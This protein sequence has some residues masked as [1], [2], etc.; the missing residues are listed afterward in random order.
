VLNA[1][2]SGVP[3]CYRQR[4]LVSENTLEAPP[5]PT[6][7]TSGE[8]RTDGGGSAL[9]LLRRYR[10]WV[11]A[12][13]LLLFSFGLLEWAKTRPGYDPFGWLVW[14]YQSIHFSLNLGGAPSWKPLPLLLT[15]PFAIFGVH[16]ELWLW[17]VS[18]V[19]ISL[20]GTIFAGRIA[21]RLI[22]VGEDGDRRPALIGAVFAGASVLG[23]SDY[24]HI[25]LSVQSDPMIV[26]LFVAA[27]DAYLSGK[28]RLAFALGILAGI[29]RPEVWSTTI[30]FTIWLWYKRPEFRKLLIAGWIFTLFMWFGIPTLTNGRPFIA[31]QLALRSPRAPKGNLVIASFHRFTG[32][33]Y[34]PVQLGALVAIVMAWRRKNWLVLLVAASAVIWVLTETALDLKGLPGQPR[35]IFEP[36]ALEGSL[37]GIA[38]G[39]LLIEA[40]RATTRGLIRI[41]ALVAVAAALIPMVPAAVARMRFEHK[42]LVHERGRTDVI[43]QLQALFNHV[44]GWKRIQ[45]CGHPVNNTEYASMTAFFLRLDV[46]EVGYLPKRELHQKKYPIVLFIELPNGWEA[47]LYRQQGAQKTSCSS[48]NAAYVYSPQHPTGTLVPSPVG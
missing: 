21:Y 14:G 48:M 38:I 40:K 20:S 5:I 30:P 9:R 15:F 25:V 34:L 3:A 27:W 19:A 47:H 8:P 22:G 26:T 33:T 1:P 39:W 32:L 23:I 37:A 2:L 29:G 35:Y 43:D 13:A 6:S 28:P 31:Y 44:G 7:A 4:L 16:D 18:S 45:Y 24:M 10:W 41:G 46:G 12:A 36:A 42:D 11:G 17:M